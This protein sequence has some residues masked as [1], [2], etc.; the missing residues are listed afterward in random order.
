M[1]TPNNL[2]RA[3]RRHRGSSLSAQQLARD[4][5]PF[6]GDYAM[7]GPVARLA[8]VHAEGDH[9]A[10]PARRDWP[11]AP[12][13]RVSRPPGDLGPWH[14]RS[15]GQTIIFRSPDLTLSSFCRI[16]SPVFARGRALVSRCSASVRTNS[17]RLTTGMLSASTR[18]W[19]IF[20]KHHS[21]ARTCG[22]ADL[23]P[24]PQEGGGPGHAL[25]GSDSPGSPA[26]RRGP[27]LKGN[28]FF[29]RPTGLGT[30]D[31]NTRG[32]RLRR[33]GHEYPSTA[34]PRPSP[35]SGAP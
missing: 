1:R 23:T 15:P 22:H 9:A 4:A 19:P 33:R 10:Q 13:F 11:S 2:I 27:A 8:R 30:K 32:L 20:I 12:A 26:S 21:H 35:A 18:T 3:L 28:R 14:A 7:L 5:R 24:A 25:A 16:R 34:S 6:P 29:L 17:S 31:P